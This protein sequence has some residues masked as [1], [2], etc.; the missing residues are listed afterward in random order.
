LKIFNNRRLWL[1][2][3]KGRGKKQK[4]GIETIPGSAYYKLTNNYFFGSSAFF[5]QQGFASVALLQSFF[6]VPSAFFSVQP[7]FFSVQASFLSAHSFLAG[8]C[9]KALA[10]TGA[11]SAKAKT[12]SNETT[13]LFFMVS[14]LMV[15][16]Q[17]KLLQI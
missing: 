8:S 2:V 10:K 14:F 4:P 17:L 13:N 7:S 11:E 15:Y 6:S 9:G 5:E 1:L 3:D 16:K 12:K